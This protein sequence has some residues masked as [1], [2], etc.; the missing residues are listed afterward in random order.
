MRGLKKTAPRS[1]K[2]YFPLFFICMTMLDYKQKKQ[3]FQHML[4]PSLF[5]K[6]LN[7]ERLLC[8]PESRLS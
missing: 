2:Q 7:K 8:L 5:N 1:H 3:P 4:K 6:G